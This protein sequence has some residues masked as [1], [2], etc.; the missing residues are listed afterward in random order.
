M[1]VADSDKDV[2]L[3]SRMI[4][5][6]VTGSAY[7]TTNL[8]KK[9]WKPSEKP[10]S[11]FSWKHQAKYSAR[12][13]CAPSQPNGPQNGTATRCCGEELIPWA[14]VNLATSQWRH[15]Q[16]RPTALPLEQ[17][18]SPGSTTTAGPG[19]VDSSSAL[20]HIFKP[21]KK[22]KSSWFRWRFEKADVKESR[23]PSEPAVA[24]KNGSGKSDW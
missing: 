7:G 4:K 15:C 10:G 21:R 13:L 14:L 20:F 19:L 17:R 16:E 11:S 2:I 22:R 24:G 12:V 5:N 9:H 1:P 23:E 3:A 6:M 8:G 18:D